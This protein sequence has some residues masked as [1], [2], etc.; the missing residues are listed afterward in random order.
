MD[1]ASNGKATSQS[2]DSINRPSGFVY[3]ISNASQCLRAF[4]IAN[5]VEW[6]DLTINNTTVRYTIADMPKITVDN[7]AKFKVFADHSPID[8]VHAS[9]ISGLGFI[10]DNGLLINEKYSSFVFLAECITNVTPRQYST[11]FTEI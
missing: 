4:S 8:E 5:T 6:F 3:T 9:C 2:W 11:P 7:D 1:Y 10:G